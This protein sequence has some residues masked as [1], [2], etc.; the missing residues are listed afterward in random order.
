MKS[1]FFWRTRSRTNFC[2][3]L[4]LVKC[5]V[6]SRLNALPWQFFT[7]SCLTETHPTLCGRNLIPEKSMKTA[8]EIIVIAA[9]VLVATGSRIY[10]PKTVS[11]LNPEASIAAGK[12]QISSMLQSAGSSVIDYEQRLVAQLKAGHPY[13]DMVE[14]KMQIDSLFFDSSDVSPSATSAQASPAADPNSVYMPWSFIPRDKSRGE[15]FPI[16]RPPPA[17]LLVESQRDRKGEHGLLSLWKS[18]DRG[19][20]K[21]IPGFFRRCAASE[22]HSSFR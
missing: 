4:N 1:N 9:I 7:I 15:G 3:R 6:S 11:G 2:N 21:I 12:K 8:R 17:P 18:P 14:L 10:A 19:W 13:T 16:V 5:Y 20:W 22:W